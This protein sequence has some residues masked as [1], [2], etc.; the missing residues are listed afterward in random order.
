MTEVKSK[1]LEQSF[2]IHFHRYITPTVYELGFTP[3]SQDFEFQA[4]QFISI[5]IPGAG[6]QGRNLRRAY[7]IASPPA[8]RPIEL[9]IKKVEGGPGSTFLANLREGDT[10]RGMAPYGDFVYEPKE[11]R[12]VCFVATG[13][14]IAPFRGML[15]SQDFQENPPKETYA[16]YGCRTREE[17]LYSEEFQSRLGKRFIQC[18]SKLPKEEALKPHEFRG[19]VTDALRHFT[20]IQFLETDFYLCGAGEMISEIKEILSAKGVTKE[21]IHQEKYY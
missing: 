1:P 11:G 7:S 18:L 10:F 8:R 2:R 17:Y 9:C 15:L 3:E 16:L 13:T 14:G 6:P 12:N 5:I 21:A 4:G 19:R 20:E